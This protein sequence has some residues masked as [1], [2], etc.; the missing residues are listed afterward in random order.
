MYWLLDLETQNAVQDRIIKL[1]GS[2]L[3]QK[4][5]QLEQVFPFVGRKSRGISRR[6]IEALTDPEGVVCDPFL[7][8]G[9]F[10]YA[11]LDLDRSVV[12]N[13]WEPFAYR[14][15]TLPLREFPSI[16]E[17]DAACEQLEASIGPKM[18]EIYKTK[19]PH[20]GA[21]FMFDGLFFDRV[22]K[23]YFNPTKHARMG[24]D[25]ENVIYRRKYKC[26]TCGST[27]AHYGQFDEQVRL[28][29]ESKAVDFPDVQLIENSRINF[30]SP[31]F[32]RYANLF[33]KRQQVALM[34]LKEGIEELPD[35]VQDFFYSVFLS[36]LHI[37]KY[38]DYHSKSQDNHCPEVMLKESNLYHKYLEKVEEYKDY[39]HAQSFD[40]AKAQ[41]SCCDF[42]EFLQR[43]EASSVDLVMTDPPYGDNAQYFEQAQRIHPFL[44]YSLIDDHERLEKEVVISNAPSRKNKSSREQLFSDYE[45]LFSEARRVVK[46]HGFF[47]MYFRP[48]QSDW[49]RDLNE[50]KDMARRNGFEP[51][52]TFPLSN[53]DP[54]LRVLASVAWA[55]SKD[56]CFVFLRLDDG[57]MRW[58]EDG[59]D[60]DEL[61]YLAALKASGGN[62][63]P[64]VHRRFNE[65]LEDQLRA[66]RL[67]RLLS[68]Q[69]AGKIESTLA[70]FTVNNGAQYYLQL[71]PPYD[72]NSSMSA[73]ARVRE[74]VPVVV[75]ELCASGKGF[76][77]EDFIIRLST[78]IENGSR[79]IIRELHDANKLVPEILLHY[80][81]Q[82]EESG[83]F[84]ARDDVIE[85]VDLNDRTSIRVMDPSSFEQLVADWLIARGYVKADVVGKPGDRGVDVWATNAQGELEFWQCKRYRE[86]NNIGSEAIQRIHSNMHSR[87]GKAGYVVTTSDFTAD[88][89][90]EGRITGVQLINGEEFI[91]SLEYH[92]PGKYSL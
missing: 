91:Q 27:A 85:I 40:K 28:A 49:L 90:D 66:N 57:E 45:S 34:T 67:M 54:S 23:E 38:V 29:M 64:F 77:F 78:Y 47:V 52:Q 8:S 88:G 26:P 30:T 82:D 42:R 71:A 20:C 36:I 79:E 62:G 75:E 10:A 1:D 74:Y 16:D 18:F 4:R 48:K 72:F 46:S 39:L 51:L 31:N 6:I 83:L 50:L 61:V 68:S 73:E 2:L 41:V 9:T 92:F 89:K 21:E 7:G 12:A 37:G 86:G 63:E 33:S 58:Y 84:Y 87:N 53:S 15:S 44:D 76:T 56:V 11:A 65:C 32:T 13:E 55:F 19:C 69:H 22:P 5:E 70:R 81:D 24:K 17:I 43:L 25:G 14:M 3:A 35:D 59:I 80:V 60:V